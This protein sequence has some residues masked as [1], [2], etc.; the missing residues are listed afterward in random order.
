M[1]IGSDNVRSGFEASEAN[2]WFIA[3]GASGDD[4]LK[5]IRQLLALLP[6]DMDAV[7]MVVLHRKWNHVTRL[8][9][10]LAAGPYPIKIAMQGEHLRP[11]TVYIGT[12]ENHLTLLADKLG[13]LTNDPRAY[14]R[15]RTVD[16]P[17][18][19]LAEHAGKSAIGVI[20][21]GRL[22]DGSRGL[23]AIHA[24][25]GLTMVIER[26]DHSQG[27]PKNAIAYDGP[28]DVVGGFAEIAAMIGAIVTKPARPSE[29]DGPI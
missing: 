29:Y 5:D 21:S 2:P 19:S 28:V 20:L 10:V 17:L 7:I 22:V 9:Q 24:E 14:Y 12:P 15:N 16:L 3:V 25:G 26:P 6:R 1:F 8:R 11:S 27:M 4:G 23:A 13:G 18:T